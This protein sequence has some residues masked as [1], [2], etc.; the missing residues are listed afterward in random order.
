M[1]KEQRKR[2]EDELSQLHSLALLLR[3]RLRRHRRGV[4]GRI[5]SLGRLRG[6][7]G[8]VAGRGTFA[9]VC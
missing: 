7:V 9:A 3:Q 1:Y 4:D 5:L 6:L 8:V 2:E